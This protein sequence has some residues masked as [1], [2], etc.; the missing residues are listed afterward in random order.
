MVDLS[1][2]WKVLKMAFFLLAFLVTLQRFHYPKGVFKKTNENYNVN[3]C[4]QWE[5]HIIFKCINKDAWNLKRYPVYKR[6]YK[7]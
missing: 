7:L 2:G 1:F 6:A 3:L 5:N 4:F